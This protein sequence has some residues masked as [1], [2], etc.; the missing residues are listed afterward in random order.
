MSKKI[1][2]DISKNKH[3]EKN[4]EKA[5]NGE[6]ELPESV[7][8]AKEAAF[9]QIRAAEVKSHS[10]PQ[11]SKGKVVFRTLSGVAAS[12]AV[13]SVV[14]ITNPAWAAEI[15]VIGSVFAKIGDSL[16]FSGDY[17]KY[18]EKLEK[19]TENTGDSGT[20]N[21]EGADSVY[22]KTS[23]GVTITMTEVYCNDTAMNLAMLIQSEE[24][25]PDTMVNENTGVPILFLKH[26]TQAALSYKP[27]FVLLNPYLDGKM[28]DEY[29]YAGV[30]RVDLD[31]TT[32]NDAGWDQYYE[33]R[34]AFMEE[35]GVDVDALSNGELTSEEVCAILGISQLTDEQILSVGGPDIADYDTTLE[36][37]EE[38]TMDLKIR[39]IMGY[40]PSEQNT[41]PEMPQEFID[42][43]NLAMEEQGL[44][45]ENYE[46]F[47]EEEKE[48]VH[49]LD[50]E[51][52]NKYV[53][54]YPEMA[55]LDN[56]H[57]TW[58]L[59]GDWEFSIPIKKN[60]EDTVTKEI[61]LLD[62]KGYGIASVTRT[63]F[64]VQIN[65][66]PGGD[67]C[68]TVLDANGEPLDY[69]NQGGSTNILSI[70]DRDISKIY[71][72]VCDYMEYMDEIKGYYWS[73]DYEEKKKTKT[74]KE[75]LDERALFSAEVVFEK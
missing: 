41:T 31:E 9:A 48:F 36:I 26:G 28:T 4:I 35:K 46:N 7:N 72:Y 43:Y 68:Y 55:E 22:T 17:E 69:G 29:T 37:P 49:Q 23:N 65:E 13:F 64:E 67:Y 38:F 10:K 11:K 16:G 71:V 6:F 33:D 60:H 18:A 21:G 32:V 75:Y 52:H 59:E 44:D 8:R 30:L 58:T 54:R 66:V 53:E 45:M 47:T 70:K 62:E 20:E 27:D 2:F 34:N 42:E 56:E 61:N 5:L 1:N 15:P 40:V 24:P 74:Y 63:P 19:E 39:S 57:N 12:A 25:L 14:C 73:E 50:L 3:R 51:M